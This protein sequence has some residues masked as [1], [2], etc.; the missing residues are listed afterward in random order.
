MNTTSPRSRELESL[1]PFRRSADVHAPRDTVVTGTVPEWLQGDLVRT[2]PAVFDH[3][4]WHARHWFDGLG[5]IYAFRI[6]ASAV[7]FQSRLLASE[8]AREIADGRARLASFGTPTGRTPW[9][10]L[11]QPVQRSTD[12]TNVNVL[13]MG[14]DL[15]ALTEGARQ[16]RIDAASLRSLGVLPFAPDGLE[17]TV[18]SAHPNRDFARRKIVNVAT[19]FGALGGVVSV[20]EHGN[21]ERVRNVVG[22]WRTDRVPYMHSFGLTASRA[23]LVAHPFSVKPLDML[24]SNRGYIDHFEWRP[25][26]GTRLIVMDRASGEVS[27]HET[28]AMFVF[29]TVNAFERG[30]ETVVD[31]LAY[32]SAR[33]VEDLRVDRMAE[34]LPDLRPSLV[35]IVAQPEKRRAMVEKLSDTGFEFPSIHL[36]KVSGSDYRYAWGAAD[37]PHLDGGYPSSI[38]KVD[39]RGGATRSFCD[40]ERIYGEPIFVARPGGRDE[41]DGVLLTVGSGQ[42]TQTSALA[43]IDARSM[44]LLAHAEVPTAIPLGFHGSFIQRGAQ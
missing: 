6:G 5:Q 30:R 20:Y 2:C 13:P 4:G 14:D 9:Q 34:Q 17:G 8:A 31:V 15:V 19:K 40:G 12:N 27:E 1:A 28:D 33:I 37:G 25:E 35:R 42:R 26:A 21:G 7:T 10:R 22:S 18:M 39:L 23:V 29:H 32:P 16:L 41:D 3:G 11:V 44:A 36:L 38:V 43:I 24:W